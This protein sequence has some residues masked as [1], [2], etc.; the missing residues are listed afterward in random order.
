MVWVVP[1]AQV[2]PPLGEVTVIDGGEGPVIAKL[3]LLVPVQALFEVLVTLT[4]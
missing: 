3:P 2:S 1:A 4:W